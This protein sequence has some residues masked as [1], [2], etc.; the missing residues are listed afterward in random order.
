MGGGMGD[1]AGG[2]SASGTCPNPDLQ[3]Q[4]VNTTGQA[5]YSPTE[6]QVSAGGPVDTGLCGLEAWGNTTEAPTLSF[7][8]SGMSEYGRLEIEGMGTCDTTLLVRSPD[9]QWHFDDDGNGDLQPLVNLTG[10]LDGR[11]DVWVGTFGGQTCDT[12]IEMETWF[13]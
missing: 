12:T 10:M 11:V 2:G 13:N 6:Y 8:L 5:L 3:G 4:V 1:S 7:F 9:G